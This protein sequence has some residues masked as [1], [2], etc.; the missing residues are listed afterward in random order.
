MFIL[1]REKQVSVNRTS[2]EVLSTRRV[3]DQ[4]MQSVMFNRIL[5][6]CAC[7]CSFNLNFIWI[8]E[9]PLHVMDVTRESATPDPNS[10][11]TDKSLQQ[12]CQRKE[13]YTAR[14]E[15]NGGRKSRSTL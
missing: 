9:V 5:V 4:V 6:S 14:E 3:V 12:D 2:V 11:K 15:E 10:S 1:L 13:G 7:D 8:T